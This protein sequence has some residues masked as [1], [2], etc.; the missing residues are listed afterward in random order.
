MNKFAHKPFRTH[1]TRDSCSVAHT[2]PSKIS[3]CE[4]EP[5]RAILWSPVTI[6]PSTKIST[7]WT[8]NHVFHNSGLYLEYVASLTQSLIWKISGWG[9]ERFTI[10]FSCNCP[11]VHNCPDSQSHL[12]AAKTHIIHVLFLKDTSSW[13]YLLFTGNKRNIFQSSFNMG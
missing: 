4:C 12:V 13:L 9:V 7:I 6:L 11:I 3:T 2:N 8:I 5:E 10:T 1:F